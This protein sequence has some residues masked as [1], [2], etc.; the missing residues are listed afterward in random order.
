MACIM[1]NEFLK[2]IKTEKNAPKILE[3]LTY[4]ETICV[5]PI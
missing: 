2:M 3:Q 4:N 1:H 5:L